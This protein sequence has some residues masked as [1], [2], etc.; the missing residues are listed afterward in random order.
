MSEFT[1]VQTEPQAAVS[2]HYADADHR[3]SDRKSLWLGSRSY[4]NPATDA[5]SENSRPQV[6]ICLKKFEGFPFVQGEINPSMLRIASGQTQKCPDSCFVSYRGF[7]QIAPGNLAPQNKNWLG[8]NPRISRPS[9]CD[10]GLHPVSITRISFA[11]VVP[12]VGWPGHIFQRFAPGL[13][14]KDGNI[15]M[16]AGCTYVQD[17]AP[18]AS[19]PRFRRAESLRCGSGATAVQ[20]SWRRP[21]C[22]TAG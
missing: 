21:C 12:R 19:A 2:S 10:S 8:S 3:T 4:R 11:V 17:W 13:G 18:T 16:E 15:V 14:P 9:L 6:R 1:M 22:I 5:C 20:A 7:Y